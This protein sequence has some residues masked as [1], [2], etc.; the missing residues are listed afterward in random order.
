MFYSSLSQRIKLAAFKSVVA[1]YL[2]CSIS[3]RMQNAPSWLWVCIVPLGVLQINKTRYCRSD[4]SFLPRY[5][6]IC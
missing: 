6:L 3:K 4:V 1:S 2:F 5:N